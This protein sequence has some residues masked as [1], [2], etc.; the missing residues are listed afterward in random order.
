MNRTTW[1]FLTG[2][3][4]EISMFVDYKKSLQRRRM[5]YGF[6]IV[7]QAISLIAPRFLWP[8]KPFPEKIVMERVYENGIIERTSNNSAKPA[9]V[10][11]AYL[12]GGQLG[13]WITFLFYGIL[14]QAI[15]NKCEELFGGYFLGTALIFTALFQVLWRGNCF[16][17]LFNTVF[18]SY[19]S[20]YILVAI[21]KRYGIVRDVNKIEKMKIFTSLQN[22]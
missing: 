16:E 17:F 14:A 2:R 15:S 8:A 1:E 19:M 18:W 3:L 10:V 5:S 9:V 6:Q 12:S 4:S 7:K 11:D 21:F 13:V 20:L 22:T